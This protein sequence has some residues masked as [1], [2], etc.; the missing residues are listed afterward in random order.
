VIYHKFNNDFKSTS[1]L[2]GYKVDMGSFIALLLDTPRK[3]GLIKT[4]IF[5]VQTVN[6]LNNKFFE[7]L[8]Y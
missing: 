2:K 3:V 5:T 1:I 8:S 6:N 4:L 7:N